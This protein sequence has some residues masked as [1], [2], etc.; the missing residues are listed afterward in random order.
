M[1]TKAAFSL[2]SMVDGW[3]SERS[4]FRQG[5]FPNVSTTGSWHDVGHYTQIVWPS[6]ARVG[7]AVRASA[8]W[9][10]LV[11]RYSS[12]GNVMGERVGAISVASR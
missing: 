12:P 10:Y 7:C 4:M 3:L 1:G 6:T 5:S 8:Q 2:E 11:C 9:D